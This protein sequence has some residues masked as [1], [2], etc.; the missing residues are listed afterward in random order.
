M[1][2]KN[3]FDKFRLDGKIALV[4]GAS[5]ILGRKFCEGL[6]QSGATVAAV[7]LTKIETEEFDDEL[8]EK[9]VFFQCD[10]SNKHSVSKCVKSIVEMF[11]GIDILLNNAAT[12]TDS[13]KNF[14]TAFEDYSID[15]WKEVMSVNVDGMF[16]MAQA[17][18]PVMVSR[19][20]G[21]I[22]QTSSI[23]GLQGPDQR[24][25]EGSNYLGGSINTPAVYSAS[26][27][28]VIGLTKWLSTYWAKEGVRVNC[29]VPGGVSSGQ[30]NIF[31]NN[32]SSKVPLGRM[33]SKDEIV[34]ALIYLA[35]D[36]SSYVTG[37]VL[38]IDGGWS[39]W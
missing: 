18:G 17:V 30:N 15:V 2:N 36:A 29:I 25:Y 13:P 9:I 31:E 19:G 39:V 32:Y 26:K 33:A 8:N 3:F 22:I 21:V 12:K 5:G 4:T 28:A 7:D 6:A 14:F 20:G 35:S 34:P 10:V 23:Y 38:N 37:H 11:G 16:L 24:I 1:Q 27:A